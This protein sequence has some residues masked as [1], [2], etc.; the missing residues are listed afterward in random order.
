M[1]RLK[2]KEVGFVVREISDPRAMSVKDVGFLILDLPL[3]HACISLAFLD[4]QLR[5]THLVLLG[6]ATVIPATTEPRGIVDF[7]HS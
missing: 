7:R 4:D 3:D 6:M 1:Q 5:S 2:V